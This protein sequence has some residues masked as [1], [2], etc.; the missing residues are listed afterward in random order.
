MAIY[1]SAPPFH[2]PAL[3]TF[4]ASERFSR[5]RDKIDSITN[6]RFHCIKLKRKWCHFSTILRA[7][8]LVVVAGLETT[9]VVLF[10]FPLTGLIAPIVIGASGFVQLIAS[11]F[12]NNFISKKQK[13][14]IT[15]IQLDDEYLNKLYH[16]AQAALKDNILDESEMTELNTL[17]KEYN[18]KRYPSEPNKEVEIKPK[19]NANEFSKNLESLLQQL[20]PMQK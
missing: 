15:K 20:K 14:I 12:L 4:H 9:G 8:T 16:F 6:D 7:S 13:R 5:L 2:E 11:E 19:F 3:P 18:D 1:P 17:L 10:I